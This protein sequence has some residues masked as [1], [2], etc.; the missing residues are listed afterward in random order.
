MVVSMKEYLYLLADAVVFQRQTPSSRSCH[1]RGITSLQ[2]LCVSFFCQY[3]DITIKLVL[4][5][6]TLYV[7]MRCHKKENQSFKTTWYANISPRTNSYINQPTRIHVLNK[8][9]GFHSSYFLVWVLSVII[10]VCMGPRLHCCVWPMHIRI[11]RHLEWRCCTILHPNCND[12]C[13]NL[14][15]VYAI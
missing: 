11:R 3:S 6:Q 4:T 15:N 9:H 5:C 13:M 10:I 14:Q 2:F 12:Q 7:L 1:L 8:S